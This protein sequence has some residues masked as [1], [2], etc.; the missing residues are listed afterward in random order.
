MK[1]ASPNSYQDLHYTDYPEKN[2]D[3][4]STL[5]LQNVISEERKKT[6]KANIKQQIDPKINEKTADMNLIARRL[7]QKTIMKVIDQLVDKSIDE[8]AKKIKAE[9]KK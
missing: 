3:R 5:V 1:K 6:I 8:T 7:L 2:G 9:C 4:V